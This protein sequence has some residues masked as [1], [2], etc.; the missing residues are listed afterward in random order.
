MP[1]RRK[2][3]F[4]A[5]SMGLTLSAVAPFQ[6][7]AS[8]LPSSVRNGSAYDRVRADLIRAGYRPSPDPTER[9]GFCRASPR[10]CESYPEAE[11]CAG[12]GL[13]PCIMVWSPGR[14]GVRIFTRGEPKMISGIDRQR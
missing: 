13:A 12:T 11:S 8:D 14:G 9:A 7:K 4:F 6:A 1:F 10:Q 5:A 3:V 2:S